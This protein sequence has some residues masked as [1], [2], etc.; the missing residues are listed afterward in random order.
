[1]QKSWGQRFCCIVTYRPV[2][3]NAKNE[4]SKLLQSVYTGK[5]GNAGME[6]ETGT[7]KWEQK[8]PKDLEKV[9]Q[10]RGH[11]LAKSLR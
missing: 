11:T 5:H 3:V 9:S 7:G 8:Q 6:M 10:S 1:M 2:Q 4:A